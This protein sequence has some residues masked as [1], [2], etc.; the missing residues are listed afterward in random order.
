MR[1]HLKSLL[2]ISVILVITGTLMMLFGFLFGGIG[3]LS[4]EVSE[5]A[6]V[7][8][9]G[10]VQTVERIPMLESIA[11]INGFTLVVDKEQVSVTVNEQYETLTGDYMNLTLAQSD[12]VSNLD[13]SVMNGVFYILPSEDDRYGVESKGDVEFQCYVENETLYLSVFPASA[14]GTKEDAEIILYVPAEEEYDQI[15][16]FCSGSSAEIKVPLHGSEMQLSTI[17]G[18]NKFYN[19]MMFELFN[20][21]AGMGTVWAEHIVATDMNVDVS[22]ADVTF[23]NVSA[24]T[25]SA[26]VGMGALDICGETTGDISISCGMGNVQMELTGEKDAYNYDISGSAESVQ[27]GTDVLAGMVM[28]RWID[29]GSDK[30]IIM[31]CSMGN[32]K[33]EF[34]E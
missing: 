28:E 27:I 18:E 2:K 7:V 15:L 1:R 33:I 17:R 24:E 10:V 26:G 9:A 30:K 25:L 6:G 12:E 19:E 31:S 22:N 13:I 14:Y 8:R 20:L 21:N 11:N 3:E 29:N 4:R 16:L 23:H 5:L 32:V 34:N